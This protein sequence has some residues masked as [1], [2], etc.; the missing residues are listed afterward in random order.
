VGGMIAQIYFLKKFFKIDR[1][2]YVEGATILPLSIV[3]VGL[4]TIKRYDMMIKYQI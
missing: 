4:G 3:I 2:G 1:R